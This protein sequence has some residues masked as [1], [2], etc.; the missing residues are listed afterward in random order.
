MSTEAGTANRDRWST[1]A[2]P[3][4]EAVRPVYTTLSIIVPVYNERRTVMN[5]L[6]IVMRQDVGHL[7]KEL[8]IVDDLSTD[9]TREYLQEMDLASLFGRDGNTVKL[10]LH[11]KN[12]GKGA[13]VR[14]ALRHASG[15]LVLIQDA[16]L[17]YDPKDYP[18]LLKP[19]LDGHAD[20]VFGNRF[21]EGAHRVPRFYRYV[22]NRCFSIMCNMLT[23]LALNDVT[24]CYKVFTR[25]V[26]DRINIKSDRFSLETELTVKLAK[27]GARIYEVPIVYH[28]RTYAEGK[29]IS[30]KDGVAATYHLFRYRFRD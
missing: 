11:E 5:L 8:V 15:D 17:E 10:V 20:A 13:G 27:V 6:Q 12:M 22:L 18:E 9:G 26:L 19:I 24:A 3:L 7:A 23:N 29:K 16:D 30:W 2:H 14:T 4:E 28:G 1:A 25:E 21:H